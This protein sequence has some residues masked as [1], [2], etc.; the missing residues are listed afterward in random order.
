[1]ETAELLAPPASMDQERKSVVRNLLGSAS[2]LMVAMG[3]ER[4]CGFFANLLAARLGG[5]PAYGAYSLALSTANNIA[6]YA[7]AGIG[8]TATRFSGEYPE[9]SAGHHA[10]RRA[11]ILVS[12]VS[13]VLAVLLLLWGAG[14]IAESL[15]HNP[16]V[17]RLLQVA[18]FSSG[19]MIAFECCRGY[20]VGQ[21]N[22]RNVVLLSVAMGLGILVALPLMAPRGPQP[23]VISQALVSAGA[24]ALVAVVSRRSH[25]RTV[26]VQADDSVSVANMAGK[27]WRFGM[28]QL[29]GV[30]G[31]NAAGWWVASLVARSDQTLVQMGLFAVA[32]QLR[33]LVALAPGL[34]AQSSYALLAGKEKDTT[35]HVLGF[36]T[37]IA[38][39]ASIVL[40]TLVILPLPYLLPLLYGKAFAGGVLTASLS[41]ATAIIHMSAAPA[42]ARLGIVSL[43]LTGIINAL[44]SLL[45]FSFAFAVVVP[46][47]AAGASALYLGVHLLS[48]ALVAIAL[49][50]SDDLPAGVS[51]VLIIGALTSVLLGVIAWMRQVFPASQWI[52]AGAMVL[53][54]AIA[55]GQLILIAHQKCWLPDRVTTFFSRSRFA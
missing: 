2:A 24:I 30:I 39:A 14:P 28:I 8:L 3:V 25:R 54:A 18:A 27:V 21:R 5:A 12:A 50:R 34:L 43:K 17:K 9:G 40:G 51:G 44:W 19:A 53:I 31:L 16:S 13:A 7:G 35:E 41:V 6:S 10:L 37:F 23:M 49:R 38:T 36:G 26:S 1:M 46:N 42:A 48:A 11:L 45:V 32:N 4:G 52:L 29:A 55:I 15:L 20:L 33:N 22:L 47:G